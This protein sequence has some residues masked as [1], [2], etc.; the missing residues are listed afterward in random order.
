MLRELAANPNVHTPVNVGCELVTDEHGRFVVFLS[1]GASVHSATVQRVRVDADGVAALVEDVRTLLTERGRPGAEWEL[2]DGT[3]PVDLVERLAG[4]G[5]VPDEEEPVA[6][7]MVLEGVPPWT[8]APGVT[9]RRAESAA[10]LKLARLVQEEAFGDPRPLPTDREYEDAFAFEG[11]TGSTFLAF[12]DGEP[13]GAAYAAY[14]RWGVVLYGG[15]VLERARGRGAYRA[16][17]VARAAE[18]AAR[19]TPALVVHAG[20]MSRPILER[21]GFHAITRI[22]RLLDT[23]AVGD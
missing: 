17:I 12:V 7:G 18:A 15:A 21:V 4:F 8:P 20:K 22:D 3:E 9:A 16:L 2:G 23:F 5:I 11:I 13:V 1:R 19:G 10:E 14:T 6:A